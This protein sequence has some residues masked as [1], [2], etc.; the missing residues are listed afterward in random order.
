MSDLDIT[1]LE[2]PAGRSGNASRPP[3]PVGLD[4]YQVRRDDVW[5]RHITLA[6]LSHTYLA[7]TAA[8]APKSPD[9]GLI[10]LTLGE[11]ERLLAHLITTIPPA[12]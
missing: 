8:I 10:A 12:A 6:L 7:V 2:V 5:Y 9:S 1:L 11:T 4:Y 3:R